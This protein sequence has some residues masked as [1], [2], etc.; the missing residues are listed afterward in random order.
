VVA[1]GK[2][3]VADVDAHS[4]VA[5]DL[6]GGWVAWRFATGGRVDS[7]PTVHGGRVLFG[8]TDGWVYCVRA[9]DGALVWKFTD[10]P[11]RLVCSSGQ[12]ES[13][14]PIHGSVLLQDDIVYFCAGRSSFLDG[15]LFVYGLDAV[16]GS[17]RHKQRL[18]GP[19][20]SGNNWPSKAGAARN[21]IP[22]AST[23]GNV[24]VGGAAYSAALQ[25]ITEPGMRI[26][27]TTGFLDPSQGSRT[28]WART[29]GRIGGITSGWGDILARSDDGVFEVAGFPAARWSFFDVKH[30]GYRLKRI[31]GTGAW[32]KNIPITGEA[33]VAAKNALLVAG[34]P[35]HFPPAHRVQDYIDGY[36]GRR[37]GVLWVASPRT[38]APLARVDLDAPP[39]WDGM[40]ACEGN[41]L[42]ATVDGYLSCY[43]DRPVSVSGDRVRMP[44][45]P[46]SPL[47]TTPAPDPVLHQVT[48]R[49]SVL[50][51]GA[52]GP[53]AT[54]GNNR[55]RPS[56]SSSTTS[57]R[58]HH[59]GSGTMNHPA[60]TELPWDLAMNP[61]VPAPFRLLDHDTYPATPGAC[62]GHQHE[63]DP[64][65]GQGCGGSETDGRIIEEQ[66]AGFSGCTVEELL[67]YEY[68]PDEPTSRRFVKAVRIPAG[69]K[70]DHCARRFRGTIRAE[71]SGEYRFSLASVGDAAFTLFDEDGSVVPTGSA[72]ED[73]SD[74]LVVELVGGRSY[75]YEVL[76][77][78]DVG[79]EMVEL[80]MHHGGG[81]PELVASKASSVPDSCRSR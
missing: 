19:Y 16:D 77:V 25:P 34:R 58:A 68:Y 41:V 31:A 63:C 75:R 20:D 28:F 36:A 21:D 66:W 71:A 12:L 50:N 59:P 1:L 15:G 43:S 54:Q 80:T 61:N 76:H 49:K 64:I 5:V 6:A 22:V 13:A 27:A 14:W 72:G 9:S 38:G 30:S 67:E 35:A 40:A 37:G 39:V 26:G 57:S 69:N 24:V 47:I 32:T 29:K 65:A 48:R 79:P 11:R 51:T 33:I 78:D 23:K 81:K 10:L 8:S 45:P 55:P 52:T 42:I 70:G 56:S 60:T 74:A 4:V 73:R 62:L 2:V 17:V 44:V 7:P 3:F 46:T 53:L 18:N